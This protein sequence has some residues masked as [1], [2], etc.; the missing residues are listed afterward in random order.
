MRY[1][2]HI[3]LKTAIGTV[4]AIT[5]ARYFGLQFDLTAGVVAIISLQATKVESLKVA[6]ERLVSCVA[7]LLLAYFIFSILGYTPWALGI[8]L[9][10]FMP[11]CLKFELM[12]GFLVTT[13]LATHFMSLREAN[14]ELLRNE[15]GILLIGMITAIVLNLYMPNI[16]KDIKEGNKKIE[17]LMRNIF[18]TMA[19]ELKTTSVAIDEN[20]QFI[21]LKAALVQAMK[22]AVTEQNNNLLS[23]D[24]SNINYITMRRFQYRV[25][26]R[27]RI[28]FFRV[29]TTSQYHEDIANFTLK[30]AENI[31]K[32]I[33]CT[34]LLN[35]LEAMKEKFKKEP[36][37]KTREEFE[38]RAVLFQFIEDL[39]EF[40]EIKVDFVKKYKNFN[41]R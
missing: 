24:M 8:F 37:P 26:Q 19:N 1:F 17:T 25:M 20:E 13:V 35:E 14:F 22:L 41:N 23:N 31:S 36:L 15:I 11:F 6:M 21:K 27:M 29:Y 12:Q 9:L 2:N 4:L 16:Q 10:I 33:D 39:E 32:H 40:L 5:V 18:L 34:F 30:V 38:N 3:T 28:H 7:G